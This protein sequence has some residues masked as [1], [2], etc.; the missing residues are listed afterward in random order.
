MHTSSANRATAVSVLAVVGFVA[1]IG[2]SIWL[3]AYSTRYIPEI[4]DRFG[5]AAVYLSSFFTPEPATLSVVPTPVATT[6]LPFTPVATTTPEVV[7]TPAPVK[8]KPPTTPGSQTSTT[9]QISGTSTPSFYGL[10]DLV[11]HIDAIGYLATSSADSFVASSTVPVGSRPAVKFIIKNAGTNVAAPWRFSASIPTRSAYI[12]QSQIQQ[13][14]APGESI[15]YTLGFDQAIT[16]TGKMISV[17]ANYDRTIGESDPNNN[18]A[19]AYLT[20]LGS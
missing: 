9:Y 2:A 16:G 7:K 4:A 20:I 14:L 6:T 11:V 3:A 17:T 5:T 15:E 19:S 12:F 1:L 10:P 18:S 13:Q 8:P